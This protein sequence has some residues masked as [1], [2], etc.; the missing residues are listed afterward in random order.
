[1]NE[2]GLDKQGQQDTDRIKKDL[3]KMLANR[4]SQITE[5]IDKFTGE[6]KEA[7]L[8][9]A[10]SV[11]KDME[12]RLDQYNSRA[13]EV[14]EKVPGGLVEKTARYPW[15]AVSLALAAGLVLGGFLKSTRPLIR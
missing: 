5:E 11:K 10:D 4:V 3:N 14:V 12:V 15:V 1:M 13:Q 2:P 7:M 6:A 9:A 8:G